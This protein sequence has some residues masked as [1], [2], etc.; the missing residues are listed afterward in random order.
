LL[1]IPFRLL[2]VS[3]WAVLVSISAAIRQG[4]HFKIAAVRR[5]AGTYEIWLARDWNPIPP[6]LCYKTDLL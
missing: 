3:N 4:P 6:A 5:L 1:N 2:R